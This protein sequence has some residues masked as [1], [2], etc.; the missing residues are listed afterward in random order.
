LRDITSENSYPKLLLLYKDIT[1]NNNKPQ[2][3]YYLSILDYKDK[4]T[5]NPISYDCYIHE[6]VIT[7]EKTKF[8]IPDTTVQSYY[9]INNIVTNNMSTD[10]KKEAYITFKV[11]PQKI[12]YIIKYPAFNDVL[13][14][15]GSLFSV[16]TLIFQMLSRSFSGFYF[17]ADL[18]NSIFKFNADPEKSKKSKRLK[19]INMYT[20]LPIKKSIF[21]II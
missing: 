3:I 6:T 1:F 5:A 11:Y 9:S 14:K 21:R 15:F 2:A 10:E 4:L 19:S 13:S 20:T 16:F 18:I 7:I 12:L 17:D 8:L